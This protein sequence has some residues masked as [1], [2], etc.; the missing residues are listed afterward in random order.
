MPVRFRVHSLTQAWIEVAI[1]SFTVYRVRG[2]DLVAERAPFQTR[3]EAEQFAE[4]CSRTWPNERFAVQGSTGPTAHRRSFCDRCGRV[5]EG[6]AD[7]PRI[8]P[9]CS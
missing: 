4:E 3:P 5:F 6:A 7:G 8:C 2:Q 9:T 1:V